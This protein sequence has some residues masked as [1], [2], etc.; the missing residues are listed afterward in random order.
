MPWFE[1]HEL[2]DLI[3]KKISKK[4]NDKI[5]GISQK[6]IDTIV[7]SKFK[8]FEVKHFQEIN[9]DPNIFIGLTLYK[10]PAYFLLD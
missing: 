2:Y 8:I 3:L 7:K 9:D 4:N 10:V 6:K 5:D 1:Y